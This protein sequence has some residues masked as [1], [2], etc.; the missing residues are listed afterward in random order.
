MAGLFNIPDIHSNKAKTTRRR[1]DPV[2]NNKIKLKKGQTINDLILTARQLVEEKLGKYKDTSKCVTDIMELENFFKTTN[3][4][5]AIDTETTGLNIFSDEIVGLSVCNGKECLYVP[6]NHKS[7]VYQSRLKNQINPD[8][9]KNLMLDVIQDSRY[10]WVYHNAKFD[11][12]VF[13]TFLGTDMPDPDWDTMICA[14]LFDQDEEHSLKFQYNKYIAEE[15]EGVNRFD[16]LFKGV[17][18]DYVPLTI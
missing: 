10:K 12:G 7:P 2:N 3:D 6:L 18:F 11:L 14:Y 17:T 9:V 8:D 1:T 5:I 4:V 13:R 15:D 16:T